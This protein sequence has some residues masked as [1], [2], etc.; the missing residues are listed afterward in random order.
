MRYF[1]LVIIITGVFFSCK[2]QKTAKKKTISNDT[3][4]LHFQSGFTHDSITI[5]IDNVLV[6]EDIINTDNCIGYAGKY[7]CKLKDIKHHIKI[8]V[9]KGVIYY[10]AV[11]PKEKLLLKPTFT[12]FLGIY[13]SEGKLLF[14][15][16]DGMP[17]YM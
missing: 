4:Y 14:H 17:R 10:D 15:I 13:F 9:K 5:K 16:K 11:I 12:S 2:Q 1:Y 3:L 6:Y 7:E 8:R